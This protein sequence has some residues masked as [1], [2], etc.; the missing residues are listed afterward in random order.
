VTRIALE[1]S[2]TPTTPAAV[3]AIGTAQLWLIAAQGV[4]G[5]VQYHRELPIGL[6]EL[7]VAGAT[8]VWIASAWLVLRT[9]PVAAEP[10]TLGPTRARRAQGALAVGSA[11][12]RRADA[13]EGGVVRGRD[14]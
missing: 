5:W 4:I 10:S 13:L 1:R 12:P 2:D 9:T 7:H 3:R 8:A 14:R 11:G 6:V